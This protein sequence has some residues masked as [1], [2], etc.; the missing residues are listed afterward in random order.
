[1]N[2]QE[3]RAEL[4]STLVKTE[5]PINSEESSRSEESDR[6]EKSDHSKESDHSRESDRSEELNHSE[7]LQERPVASSS[8]SPVAPTVSS[9]EVAGSSLARQNGA[10]RIRP[11]PHFPAPHLRSDLFGGQG[12]VQLWSLIHPER[13]EP[14]KAVLWCELEPGGS[15]GAHRQEHYPELILCLSGE[16]S[17]RIGPR[18]FSFLPGVCLHLPLGEILALRAGDAA[19][20]VYIIIKAMT[21]PPTAEGTPVS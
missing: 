4:T 18:W 9:G 3:D 12:S 16:G 1:M 20:L 14:F 2:E 21:A 5:E 11:A 17:A 6:S 8:A 19:P 13:A 15:V 7:G 10:L